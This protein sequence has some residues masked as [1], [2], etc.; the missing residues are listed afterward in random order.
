MG[1]IAASELPSEPL[2]ALRELAR[3]ETELDRL[4]RA[5]V[6]AARAAGAT[7]EQVGEALGMTRQSAWEY[8]SHDT[9]AEIER[10]A[11]ANN[12]LSEADAVD[13][14]VDEVRAVLRQRR[15]R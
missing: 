9:W 2:D 13:L 5:Y 1:L 6:R 4:R 11:H 8:F 15:A 14:A 3:S 7:W 12:E 10:I